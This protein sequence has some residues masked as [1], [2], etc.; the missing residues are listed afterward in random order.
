M[1]IAQVPEDSKSLLSAPGILEATARDN[2]MRQEQR[3]A[4]TPA[5]RDAEDAKAADQAKAILKDPL[6]RAVER[7]LR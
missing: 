4:M 1:E 7:G 5:Q 2:A 3:A 6:A